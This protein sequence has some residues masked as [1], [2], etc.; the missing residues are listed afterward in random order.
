M[1]MT[2]QPLH[3][4]WGTDCVLFLCPFCYSPTSVCQNDSAVLIRVSLRA[5]ASSHIAKC[6]FC[7][8]FLFSSCSLFFFFFFLFS[9]KTF[10]CAKVTAQEIRPYV[11]YLLKTLPSRR[12]IEDQQIHWQAVFTY[13]KLWVGLKRC[14]FLKWIP[15]INFQI[16]LHITQVDNHVC[17]LTQAITFKVALDNEQPAECQRIC[18]F[19]RSV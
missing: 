15:R 1:H 7:S 17:S 19:I 8:P 4:I 16:K 5:V 12:I 2:Q 10:A 3:S 6:H 18:F 9:W 13:T 11:P 14:W